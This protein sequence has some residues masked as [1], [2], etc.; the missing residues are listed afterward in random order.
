MQDIL[1]KFR[2]EYPLLYRKIDILCN[3]IADDKNGI[4]GKV[5]SIQNPLDERRTGNAGLQIVLKNLDLPLS[6]GVHFGCEST[7]SKMSPYHLEEKGNELYVVDSRERE[8][9]LNQFC[10]AGKH[11]SGMNKT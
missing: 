7:V 2:T 1:T 3:G 5:Y 8:S 10:F 6:V 4:L 9:S 11:E